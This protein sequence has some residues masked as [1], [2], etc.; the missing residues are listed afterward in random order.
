M[1]EQL[2]QNSYTGAEAAV[3]VAER[4]LHAWCES[5]L[6]WL[7]AFAALRAVEDAPAA[8]STASGGT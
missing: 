5:K 8:R 2:T 7:D 4:G 6:A 3:G 1:V